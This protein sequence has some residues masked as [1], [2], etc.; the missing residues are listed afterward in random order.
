MNLMLLMTSTEL[1]SV[2]SS[3][4]KWYNTGLA[5]CKEAGHQVFCYSMQRLIILTLGVTRLGY[6]TLQSCIGSMLK[7]LLLSIAILDQP[8]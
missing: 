2:S 5:E 1:P 3:L 4:P 8:L 7:C 6:I